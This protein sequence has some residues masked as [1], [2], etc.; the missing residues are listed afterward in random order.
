MRYYASFTGTSGFIYSDCVNDYFLTDSRYMEQA[1][2]QCDGF[3]AVEISKEH[4]IMDFLAEKRPNRLFVEESHVTM[5]FQA[6]LKKNLKNAVLVGL[7]D[8]I[9]S[10]RIIKDNIEIKKISNAANIADKAFSHIIKFIRPGLS[11]NEIA[12]ELDFFMRRHGASGLSFETIVASGAR[13]SMPHGTAT[14]KIVK[15]GEFITMDFGC[16]YEGYCSDMTRTVHLGTASKDEKSVYSIV[17]KAQKKALEAIRDG[18]LAQ[19]VDKIAR[20]I[21][22]ENGYGDFFGHGLGHG[23]GLDVHEEPR[24]SPAGDVI[25]SSGMVITDEPG[26]Y[27]PGKFGVRIEDLLVVRKDGF[28]ILSKSPKKLI[29]I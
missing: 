14:D 24:L 12:L 22:I 16:V 23:V 11:E 6:K 25:L 2:D 28:D 18:C 7:D 21:I 4:S 29:E 20:D 3:K 19:S 17:L 10:Q 5:A 27:L 9:A 15:N 1:K 13:S 8:I 26:I